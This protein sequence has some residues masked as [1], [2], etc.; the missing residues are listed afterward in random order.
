MDSTVCLF[1]FRIPALLLQYLA[2]YLA[3]TIVIVLENQKTEIAQ[4]LDKL[5]LKLKYDFVTISSDSDYGTAD[6]LRSISERIK[7]DVFLISCDVVTNVDIYPVLN[8]FRKNDASVVSLFFSASGSANDATITIPG[9][10]AKHKQ[11]R[12][13]VGIN[14][15]NDRLLFLA[16]T[17]DFEDTMALPA[18]LLRSHGKMVVHSSLVDAH[19]YLVKKWVVDYLAKSDHF[20]T[21]KGELLPF[22]IKKQMSRPTRADNFGYSEVS[23]DSNDIF[24]HVKQ[25]ELDQKVLETNLNN[26]SRL[27]KSHDAELIRCFAYIA[28][29]ESVGIRVN[30]MLGFCIANKK[31]FGIWDSLCGDAPLVSPSANIHSTQMSDCAVAD[32]TSISEKTSIKSTVFGTNSIVHEKTRINDSYIMNNVT[33][34]ELVQLEN[35]IICDKAVVRKGSVLK[36]CLVGFNFTVQEGTIKDKAHLTGEGFMEIE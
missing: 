10:K 29:A 15:E 7:S 14:P 23:F 17:S 28:P 12:D 31:V 27:K 3:E 34:E 35:C 32:Y 21:I 33:I 5:P 4:R 8:M 19:V 11:E 16:S 13:L 26:F 22:I 9:P 24:E 20:S 2:I 30:T 6:A 1:T 18:H 25:D 36:N